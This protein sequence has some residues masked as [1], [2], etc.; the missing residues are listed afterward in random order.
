M[1]YSKQHNLI[2]IHIPKNAGTSIE[3]A[4]EIYGKD[5][6]GNKVISKDMAFGNGMQHYTIQ[7]L[8]LHLRN[9]NIQANIDRSFVV[10][11]NP[12]DRFLSHYNW[13]PTGIKSGR[14]IEEFFFMKFLPTL[15]DNDVEAKH[16]WPQES[17]I[18]DTD[19]SIAVR[20]LL[21][22]ANVNHGF[23][24][25]KKHL[26]INTDK[27][28]GHHKKSLQ[29]HQTEQV[30]AD[31]IIEFIEK[32]YDNDQYLLKNIISSETLIDSRSI[33]ERD[34]CR[35]KHLTREDIQ[36][37]AINTILSINN[38]LFKDKSLFALSCLEFK[39]NKFLRGTRYIYKYVHRTPTGTAAIIAILMHALIA[40]TYPFAHTRNYLIK[41]LIKL[42]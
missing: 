10:I 8:I 31:Y 34:K 30:I 24:E 4:L 2:F 3:D 17:Y 14:T 28:L 26:D 9:R 32:F 13:T 40:A 23:K 16:R 22:F 29:T 25:L 6:L 39:R 19:S 18:T 7:E 36:D 38:P 27:E 5:A 15:G 35:F 1:P 42:M 11:R 20:Y 12:I 33:N 37:R 21:N 41:K